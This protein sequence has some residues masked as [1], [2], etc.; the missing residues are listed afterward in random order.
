[1]STFSYEIFTTRNN[2]YVDNS[3]QKKIREST[4]LIAGCGIGSSVAICAARFWFERFILVDGDDIAPHNLNRQFYDFDDVGKQKTQALKEKILKINPEA[5]V[6]TIDE[7]IGF[8]NIE[9]VL[10][11]VDIVF[12][13]IDF[14]DF[15]WVL[16]LHTHARQ[17]KLPIMTALN[18]WFWGGILYFPPIA[19]MSL[20]DILSSDIQKSQDQNNVSY[21]TVYTSLIERIEGELDEQVVEE[22][23][24]ALTIMEDGKP[25]PASQ[26]SV[27]T[28][29]IAAMAVSIMHDIIS[30]DTPPEAPNLLVYNMR[31]HETKL[32]NLITWK[33]A[34]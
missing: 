8:G 18:I 2:G 20:I 12:D 6:K 32:I 17:K 29:T 4:I 30:W 11:G 28:F 25:C 33:S 23:K 34:T 13:T 9:N 31:K 14:L 16:A 27:G 19:E 10:D 15:N 5:Y 3:N 1:M 24:K 21:T 7:Y 22:I 26:V